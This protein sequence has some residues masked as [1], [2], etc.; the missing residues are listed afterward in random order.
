MAKRDQNDLAIYCGSLRVL[1]IAP[2][3]VATAVNNCRQTS[4]ISRTLGCNGHHEFR[5]TMSLLWISNDN[6]YMTIKKNPQQTR[7]LLVFC[8]CRLLSS[9]VRCTWPWSWIWCQFIRWLRANCARTVWCA[10]CVWTLFSDMHSFLVAE[11][12]DS[13]DSHAL[14]EIMRKILGK[15]IFC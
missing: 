12:R 1:A 4:N 2:C 13:S 8:C 6:L 14:Q 10:I 11:L 9:F 3:T 7:C 15:Q 5:S